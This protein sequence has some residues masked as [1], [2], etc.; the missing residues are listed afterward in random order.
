M[1]CGFRTRK[2]QPWRGERLSDAA[3]AAPAIIS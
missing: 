3:A 1:V 2:F